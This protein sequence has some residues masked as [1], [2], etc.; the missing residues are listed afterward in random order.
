GGRNRSQR[1]IRRRIPGAMHPSGAGAGQALA[2]GYPI[3]DR[4]CPPGPVAQRLVQGTHNP[5][6]AGSNP[7][8]PTT[9]H[10][11]ASMAAAY[12]AHLRLST[13]AMPVHTL[14]LPF[15]PEKTDG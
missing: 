15:G 13:Q 3:L 12:A 7:A 9:R 11:D 6:V 5:L 8:R 14:R 10:S 1:P 4:I 2:G